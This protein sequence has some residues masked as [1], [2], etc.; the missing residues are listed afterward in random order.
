M[1]LSSKSQKSR[2]APE[3]SQALEMGQG[4]NTVV[5][6]H[7]LFGSPQHWR[8]MMVD[9]ADRY[10]VFA[11]QLPID[12][13]P[14][15]RKTGVRKIEE[16]SDYVEKLL[17]D[18]GIKRF[19]MCGNSLGG[20][21]AIDMCL[22]HPERAAGLV[23]AG[24]AGLYERSLT[25]GA[26]PRPTREFVRATASD[27]LYNKK[28]ITDQLV[29]DWYQDLTDRD[30]I[31]FVLRLARATRDRNI[32]EELDKLKLPALMIWGRNDA[33]TP[34]SVAKVFH[35]RIVDSQLRFIDNCGHAPNLEQPAAFSLM[36]QEFLPRCFP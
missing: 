22:R 23:L 8:P 24:S 15:R 26:R 6:I 32:K 1:F 19:V 36:L 3:A 33:V 16:I 17:E 18:S 35:N 9:L 2:E 13:H 20:L 34:P 5:F 4:C 28:M 27:I 11:P 21:V 31:R 30:Y 29:D 25:N 14:G 12:R 7:G 10:R